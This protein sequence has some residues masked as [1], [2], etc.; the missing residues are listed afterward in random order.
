MS[1]YVTFLPSKMS[2]CG[3]GEKHSG[4]VTLR[5]EPLAVAG[6]V[7]AEAAD[8][9]AMA[10]QAVEPASPGGPRVCQND[11]DLTHKP[12]QYYPLKETETLNRLN[13]TRDACAAL[14]LT[15]Y[16]RFYLQGRGA[17]AWLP[18]S[19]VIL[20]ATGTGTGAR[21][22]RNSECRLNAGAALNPKP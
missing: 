19:A 11:P 17:R 1:L 21:I 9:V 2:A 13:E 7:D 12:P 15:L 5:V 10:E 4:S 20:V 18:L 8:D 3:Q 16:I 14:K 22:A 6:K